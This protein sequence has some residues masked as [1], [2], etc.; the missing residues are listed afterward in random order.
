MLDDK[1]KNKLIQDDIWEGDP[2]TFNGVT[3]SRVDMQD[4]YLLDDMDNWSEIGNM[5]Q[6]IGNEI[7]NIPNRIGVVQGVKN[8]ING[9]VPLDKSWKSHDPKN[10]EEKGFTMLSDLKD[11][12]YKN[13]KL[14][15]KIGL[16]NSLENLIGLAAGFMVGSMGKSVTSNVIDD[17]TYKF[18][19]GLGIAGLLENL[20]TVQDNMPT[21]RE[22]IE[23]NLANFYTMYTAKPG[24]YVRNRKHIFN[25]VTASLFDPP[26][27]LRNEPK[28]IDLKNPIY[29]LFDKISGKVTD[30]EDKIMRVLMF[31]PQ[32]NYDKSLIISDKRDKYMNFIR[33]KNFLYLDPKGNATK[34]SQT[35]TEIYKHKPV[36]DEMNYENLSTTRFEPAERAKTEEIAGLSD[37]ESPYYTVANDINGMTDEQ[38]GSAY[39]NKEAFNNLDYDRFKGIKE[40]PSE[41]NDV[42]FSDISNVWYT[43]E[44][45]VDSARIN[46]NAFEDQ[47]YDR[48]K[49]LSKAKNKENP[50]FDYHVNRDGK[51]VNLADVSSQYYEIDDGE[52]FAELKSE[53]LK[54]IDYDNLFTFDP[55]ERSKRAEIAKA[56]TRVNETF[57][58]IGCLYVE[59]YYNEQGLNCFDI[60][61]EF[62]PEI[63]EGGIQAQY[64][65]EKVMGRLLG[66]KSYTSTDAEQVTINTTYIATAK[67]NKRDENDKIND[68]TYR[69]DWND[70]GAPDPWLQ[71]W[72]M[73]WTTEKLREIELKY[74]SLCYPYIMDGNFVRPPIVRIVMN[75]MKQPE[76]GK[77]TPDLQ[78]VGDLFS[79]PQGM[80]DDKLDVTRILDGNDGI[81]LKRYIVTNVKIDPIDNNWATSYTNFG[82]EEVVAGK[83]A[84][85]S[86][87]SFFRYGFKVSVTLS[88]TT[89]NFLDI[90]PNYN[91][92]YNAWHENQGEETSYLHMDYKNKN[93]DTVA[94][95][96]VAETDEV[97][98]DTDGW[99]E[100]I[101]WD[102]NGN[103]VEKKKGE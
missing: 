4:K 30:K 14:K 15:S 3:S 39:L 9:F 21:P 65:T 86:D 64:E 54:N 43:V 41:L 45:D 70:G 87:G 8:V 83:D 26:G 49:G 35:E 23:L 38:K 60:P 92:Y 16:Y 97:W 56:F 89:K 53:A 71:G 76:E 7:K 13:V 6:M 18:T 40:A 46:P 100:Y 42:E 78:Y 34:L 99:D 29:M 17:M 28:L 20:E 33:A 47:S 85:Q 62:N 80:G 93:Y 52:D 96:T 91:E 24:R 27:E 102:K 31:N 101:T 5:P 57:R 55:S 66:L 63:S 98:Y 61:F 67:F 103:L 88:E 90:V 10:T 25:Y 32:R 81:R 48:F 84:S 73:D 69:A 19:G 94:E 75:A 58:K 37:S 36:I 77:E 11:Q 82:M 44:T 50:G 72:M 22:I 68:P 1:L 79:Y 95:D 59:P 12:K 51:E 2:D 74:R